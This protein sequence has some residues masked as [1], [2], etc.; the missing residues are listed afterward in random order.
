MVIV[1]GQNQARLL[2]IRNGRIGTTGLQLP[3][4]VTEIAF[5]RNE[6]RVLFKTGLWIHRALVSPAGLIWTDAT[7]APKSLSGSRMAFDRQGIADEGGLHAVHGNDR[8][9]VLTR[10]TGFAEI[11]E[12]HFDYDA[13][14]ALF[15]NRQNLIDEWTRKVRGETPI[16]FVREGF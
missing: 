7:R 16:G 1:D 3:D 4:T 2:D 8:V 12:I 13:G 10:D 6:A 5:S 11:V 15:G 14:P 9:L